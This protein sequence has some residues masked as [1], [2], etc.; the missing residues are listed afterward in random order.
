MALLLLAGLVVV[1]LIQ[2]PPHVRSVVLVVLDTVRADH[3]SAYGY[4]KPTTPRLDRLAAE[5]LLFEHARATAP[6]TLPSHASLFTGRLAHQHGCHWEHRWLADS[7][8]TMAERLRDRGFATLGVTTNPN[9]SSLY[10]LDQGFDDFRETWR[11]R[12]R[13]R[14]RSDSAIANAEIREWL[15]QRDDGR[16]FFLFVNYAD[17]HLPYAPPPPYDRLF[18]IANA[19]A[20]AL[21]GRPDLLQ[22]TLVGDEKVG[23]QDVPGLSALYDGDVRTADERLGELVDLLD[24]LG[25]KDD[26]LLIVT[27]DHGE[28]LGEGGR[29]DHQLSLAES[30]LRVPLVVRYPRYVRPARVREPVS[31]ADIKGWIDDFADS[32]VPEWS[33]PPDRAPVAFSAQYMRPVD[34]VDFVSARGGDSAAINRRIA[35]ALLP[36]DART[37]AASLK[38]FVAEPGRSALYT[39]DAAGLEQPFDSAAP[40]ASPVSLARE[41][42]VTLRKFLVDT[43]ALDPF[44]EQDADLL[45][46]MPAALGTTAELTEQLEELRKL[47]YVGSSGAGGVSI[48]ASEHWS[49]GLRMQA[50]GELELAR[51]E[52]EK[53]RRLAPEEPAIVKALAEVEAALRR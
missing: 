32:R 53:A 39:I 7:Q 26:T 43:Y 33:P 3:C 51:L 16:P 38:L 9:A 10:H 4:G 21:A 49:A 11:L 34:L 19:R 35:A 37:G 36:G 29:V 47:G 41:G 1:K 12:E 2:R 22:A 45:P 31:L 42:E 15:E 8:E 17:A 40:S 18:G 44:V 25:L 5:G 6:W 14:G 20:T 50:R 24:E 23:P 13:H 30:L 52:L 48:H 46:A 28:L 27:S